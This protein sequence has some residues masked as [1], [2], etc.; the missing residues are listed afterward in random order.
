MKGKDLYEYRASIKWEVLV[1]KEGKCDLCGTGR[2][3][4]LHEIINRG[5]TVGNDEARVL[6]FNRHIC[7][8]LCRDC[9]EKAH[10]PNAAEKLLKRNIAFYGYEAVKAAWDATMGAMRYPPD[11]EFPE[12]ENTG[13]SPW[14]YKIETQVEELRALREFYHSMTGVDAISPLIDDLFADGKYAEGAKIQVLDWSLSA[15]YAAKTQE[16]TYDN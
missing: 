4:D 12:K 10:N 9:H 5:R 8:L 14:D 16:I 2:G 15:Y 1:E 13:S 7:S 6:S 3:D 11:M